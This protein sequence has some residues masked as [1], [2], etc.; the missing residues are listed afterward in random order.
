MEAEPQ[1]KPPLA[2]QKLVPSQGSIKG[3][4]EV[5]LLG[6]GFYQGL[7]V[8]FGDTEA[9]ATTF[10]G[11]RCLVCEAPPA[12]K[13]GNVTIRCKEDSHHQNATQQQLPFQTCVYEYIEDQESHK[14]GHAS[15]AL[16]HN[17]QRSREDAKSTPQQ[18]ITGVLTTTLQPSRR[19]CGVWSC[20]TTSH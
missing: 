12:I 20:R 17:K 9:T 3:G 18:Q 5:T 6:N 19:R 11:D 15:T 4:A 2:I 8:V 14:Y 16:E 7:E 13:A 10:W 1:S